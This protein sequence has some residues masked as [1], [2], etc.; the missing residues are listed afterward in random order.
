MYFFIIITN[1]PQVE[2]SPTQL[3]FRAQEKI[4]LNISR[5]NVIFF[6]LSNYSLLSDAID[7]EQEAMKVKG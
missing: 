5:P 2:H 7:S 1:L 3:L 4:F 6:L